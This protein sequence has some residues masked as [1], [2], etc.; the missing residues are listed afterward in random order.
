[1]EFTHFV[2]SRGIWWAVTKD[3]DGVLRFTSVG[4]RRRRL[5][6]PPEGWVRLSPPD[7]EQLAS[8]AESISG[9]DDD[10]GPAG[11][12]AALPTGGP[13]PSSAQAVPRDS[14]S[15]GSSDISRST[16]AINQASRPRR[17]PSTG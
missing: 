16:E 1:V 10:D 6:N 2:D 5:R 14:A 7:L 4:G 17:R 15:P 3:P 8:I 12:G 13:T 11:R 9:E